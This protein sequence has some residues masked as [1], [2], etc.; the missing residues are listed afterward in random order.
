M[1]GL[2]RASIIAAMMAAGFMAP[3]IPSSAGQNVKLRYEQPERCR[4][5]RHRVKVGI[6]DELD[7]LTRGQRHLLRRCGA[8]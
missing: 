3:A 5:R 2:T 8:R 7:K 6:A 4:K 1:S